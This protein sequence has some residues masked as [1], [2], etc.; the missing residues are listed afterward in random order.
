MNCD[1]SFPCGLFL[2]P[3]HYVPGRRL[4]GLNLD[5][6]ISVIGSSLRTI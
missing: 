3:G 5:D 2:A 4:G 1:I 6:S